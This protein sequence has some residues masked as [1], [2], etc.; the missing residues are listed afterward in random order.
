MC[1]LVTAK[2]NI[3]INI[4]MKEVVKESIQDFSK[5][6]E[7]PTLPTI[8]VIDL[9]QGTISVAVQIA[10]ALQNY[11]IV[12]MMTDRLLHPEGGVKVT[13]LGRSIQINKNPFEVAYNRNVPIVA[14]FSLRM[15]DYC[16][17]VYY[18]RLDP[19]DITLLKE[20]AIAIT[21]QKYADLLEKMVRDYPDQWFN[22][23]DF[24]G[25]DA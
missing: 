17:N 11:E 19:F 5:A 9:N 18:Y 24:F 22:H 13:F 23:Y 20:E 10:K 25:D 3:P 6:I 15:D 14:V 1:G 8:N 16:Y 7:D 21:A 4:V 2:K 12:A